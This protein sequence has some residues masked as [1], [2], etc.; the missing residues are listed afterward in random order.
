MLCWMN[1]QITSENEMFLSPFDHGVLY[2]H[3]SFETFRSYSGKVVFLDYHF[4]RLSH[5]LAVLH[6]YIP[7]TLD[8]FQ[9]AITELHELGEGQDGVY[10][11]IVTAGQPN[12]A[13]GYYENPNVIIVRKPIGEIKRGVEKNGQWLK[14]NHY[15]RN[16]ELV[17]RG[18]DYSD[19]ILGKME[20]VD[21]FKY[22]GLLKNERGMITEGLRSNIFWA[23]ND[24][25]YTPCL[26]TGIVR[27]I[28]REWIIKLAKEIGYE[29]REGEFWQEDLEH[30]YEC[31]ITNSVEELVAIRE[32]GNV[33]FAGNEGPV[34]NRLYNAYLYI[35]EQKLKGEPYVRKI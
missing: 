31:F 25:I 28:T 27:G 35:V 4:S 21:S 20:L 5:T 22:E 17:V 13:S 12:S 26:S 1:G 29:V 11:I 14:I 23:K 2:G 15:P 19:Y 16:K 8:E 30:A 9:R 10:K 18:L 24:I 32:I 33:R 6:I 3:G 34:Y 7:F